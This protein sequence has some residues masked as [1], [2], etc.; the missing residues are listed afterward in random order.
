MMTPRVLVVEDGHEYINNL[1]RFLGE[2]FAFTRAGDGP[3]AL[4][5]LSDAPFEAIFLDMKFDRADVLL[6]DL[7]ATRRRFAG[8][9]TRARRF[10]ENN[11]GAYVLAAIREAG[12]SQP[13]IFSYDFDSEPRRFKNLLRRYGPLRYLNDTAT[14]ADIRDTLAGAIQK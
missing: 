4:E 8:D 2:D 1:T 3:A 12:H 9:E 10:L 14:P 13:A 7:D 11:Q 5:L 6:G